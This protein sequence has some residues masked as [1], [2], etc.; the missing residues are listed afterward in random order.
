[1]K[2]LF[3]AVGLLFAGLICTA[4]VDR[5]WKIHDVDRPVPAVTSPGTP[6]TQETPGKPPSDAV[7]LFDGKDASQWVQMDGSALKWKVDNG[8][9]EV[10]PTSGDIRTRSAFGDCQ[11][12]VEF[13]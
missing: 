9:L 10:V 12:H 13:Q 2:L 6:S 11:L 5:R 7:V 1:M 4:Q 8:A 3:S